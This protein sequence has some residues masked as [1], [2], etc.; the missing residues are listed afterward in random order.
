MTSRVKRK[1]SVDKELILLSIALILFAGAVE[2]CWDWFLLPLFDW[3]LPSH[4]CIR[5]LVALTLRLVVATSIVRFL[6]NRMISA[7]FGLPTLTWLDALV[8]CGC[9][10]Y[11]VLV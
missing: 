9:F 2:I 8:L 11:A 6:W 3:V 5:F 4:V 7:T 10:Y 1:N